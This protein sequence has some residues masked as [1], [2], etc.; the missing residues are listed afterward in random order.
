MPAGRASK[1]RERLV[2]RIGVT[3][4][5]NVGF[6]QVDDTEREAARGGC[7]NL[8]GYDYAW[9]SGGGTCG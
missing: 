3:G 7:E 9:S 1:K 2:A 5:Q 4:G 8:A 6:T